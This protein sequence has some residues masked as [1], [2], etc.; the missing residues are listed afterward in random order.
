MA[1]AARG[2]PKFDQDARKWLNDS[3]QLFTPTS[4]RNLDQATLA[5]MKREM[6]HWGAEVEF[7]QGIRV[8]Q[9]AGG[10]MGKK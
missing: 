5:E 10:L 2:N 6:V 8:R 1:K 4:L 7:Y 3:R 9:S